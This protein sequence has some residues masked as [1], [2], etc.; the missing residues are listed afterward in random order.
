MLREGG[1]NGIVLTFGFTWGIGKEG[2]PIEKVPNGTKYV[3]KDSA[4]PVQ[5]IKRNLQC[6]AQ[7]Q[8]IPIQKVNNLPKM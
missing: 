5:K 1:R 3:L 7:T 4:V 8:I 6:I 2:K